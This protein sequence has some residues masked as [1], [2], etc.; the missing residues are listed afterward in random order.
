MLIYKA[1]L[2]GGGGVKLESLICSI[3]LE[4]TQMKDK[5]PGYNK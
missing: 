4:F 1:C 2:I 5:L 3:F